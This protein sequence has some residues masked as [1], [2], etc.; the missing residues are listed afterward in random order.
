[1]QD[2]IADRSLSLK[3]GVFEF[4]TNTP[5]L[6]VLKG[7][8]L[9]SSVFLLAKAESSQKSYRT[10]LW[11]FFGSVF[12]VPYKSYPDREL[13]FA[14]KMNKKKIYRLHKATE[15]TKKD[16]PDLFLIILFTFTMNC[17]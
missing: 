5:L 11:T 17:F 9:V 10:S 7:F 12:V 13:R 8:L 16:A 1:M 2:S 6:L 3:V 4:V 14:G 15:T